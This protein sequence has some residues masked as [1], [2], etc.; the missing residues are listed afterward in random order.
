M[1]HWITSTLLAMTALITAAGPL[2]AV[3]L[4]ILL[5]EDFE[6]GADRWQPMDPASWK[7]VSTPEG[8]A[9]SLFQQSNYKPPFRSPVNIALLK[10][11][12]VSDFVLT[13]RV[14]STVKDYDHRSMVL[15]FGYQNPAHYYYVHFGKKADD[16]ANQIF[17]VNGAPRV[18]ISKTSTPGTPWDDAWHRVKIVRT[19][20]DGK[21]EIYF[22]NFEQPVMTAENKTF[23]YGQIGIG[24]FDDLGEFDDLVLRGKETVVAKGK[25]DIIS[26]SNLKRNN[27]K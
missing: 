1:R 22:D 14:R 25:L 11:P 3:E 7:V 26:P 19:V 2:R 8:K 9:Y 5:S 21:I 18:K 24:A 4:P 15:I 17:I 16:H 10:E 13:T 12:M 27:D 6:S 20:A 23:A